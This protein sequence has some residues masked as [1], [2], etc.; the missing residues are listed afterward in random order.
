ML[1]VTS[2]HLWTFEKDSYN[3]TEE[4][5]LQL[6]IIEGFTISEDSES[7]EIVMHCHEDQDERFNCEKQ[8]NK[9]NLLNVVQSLVIA[10]GGTYVWFLVPENKL[11][12]YATLKADAE[13]KKY[14]R[15][16]DSTI[17]QDHQPPE[18]NFSFATIEGAVQDPT[19]A[20]GE[21][22]ISTKLEHDQN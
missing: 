2:Q 5:Q 11:R 19:N 15:P 4:R 16:D 22:Q 9:I 20:A 12:K 13:K 10:Q 3:Y 14:K 8:E 1:V 6:K 18:A 17:V 7:H 21:S